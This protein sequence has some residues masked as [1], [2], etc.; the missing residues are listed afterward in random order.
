VKQQK[1]EC[2]KKFNFC[3]LEA[4]REAKAFRALKLA[5]DSIQ[6]A[7]INFELLENANEPL[8]LV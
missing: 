6:L 3:K 1:F 7:R 8:V 4:I 2:A 5:V